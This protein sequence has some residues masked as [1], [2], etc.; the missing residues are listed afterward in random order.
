MFSST[1]L[2][3]LESTTRR[4]RKGNCLLSNFPPSRNKNSRLVTHTPF[5]QTHHQSSSWPIISNIHHGSVGLD[6]YGCP[7]SVR[8]SSISLALSRKYNHAYR[9]NTRKIRKIRDSGRRKVLGEGYGKQLCIEWITEKLTFGTNL[10]LHTS[11][12]LAYFELLF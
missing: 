8:G 12:T 11:Y 1:V 2:C 9:G 3:V 7:K 5:L 6:E 4:K 10:V